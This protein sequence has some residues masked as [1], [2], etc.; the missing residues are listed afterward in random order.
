MVTAVLCQTRVHAAEQVF[1]HAS[2]LYLIRL[3][4]TSA[5]KLLTSV[6]S[7]STNFI[8]LAYKYGTPKCYVFSSRFIEVIIHC[9]KSEMTLHLT[10]KLVLPCS[11]KYTSHVKN[12]SGFYNFKFT[13]TL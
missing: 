11:K 12:K 5:H 8:Y 6:I 13:Q 3:N 1:T 4:T 7:S 2:L 10:L 9:R